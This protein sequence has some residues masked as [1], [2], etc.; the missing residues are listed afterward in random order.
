MF[1]YFF[2]GKRTRQKRSPFVLVLLIAIW[3]IGLGGSLAI[4]K[5]PFYHSP[6]S[7]ITAPNLKAVDPALPRYQLGE[8]LYIENCGT[9]HLAIPP[10][11]LPT[12][13][14]L[15]LIQDAQHY[16]VQIR[17]LVDPQRL[18]VWNYLRTYSRPRTSEEQTPY[19]V[20]SSRFFRALHPNVKFSQPITL[21]NCAS[22]HIGA[23]E[24][25]FR[26]LTPEW[27]E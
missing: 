5:T 20:A 22:C 2:S 19:R 23:R 8:Q 3:S 26:T 16:G 17:P 9:C 10:G 14:W 6:A 27:V 4:A 15:D 11:L 25:D 21:S 7:E 24:Y 1:H 13:T 12:Q 18:I